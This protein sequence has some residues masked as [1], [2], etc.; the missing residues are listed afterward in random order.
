[1][2]K[3]IYDETIQIIKNKI[4]NKKIFSVVDESAIGNLKFINVLV[5]T[6]EDPQKTYLVDT[7]ST[8]ESVNNIL[9][10]QVVNDTMHNIDVNKLDNILFISDA[11]S[12]MNK[13]AET[14]KYYSLILSTS[15]ACCTCCIIVL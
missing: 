12:Y 10:T 3:Q 5:G 1:M 13:A 8:T 14:L 2:V 4:K 11:A 7:I 9:I 15:H 6:L